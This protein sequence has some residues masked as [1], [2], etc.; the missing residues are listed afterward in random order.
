MAGSKA[1]KWGIVTLAAV[2][3]LVAGG[4]IG[5]RIVVGITKGKVVEALGPE[6]EIQDLKVGWF[7][8]EI[9]GLRIKG[10]QG[11]PA[12]D[13][14]RVERVVIAPSLRSLLS[15]TIRIS[16]ITVVRPYLSALRTCFEVIVDYKYV[17][18]SRKMA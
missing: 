11:W 10:R 1:M 17:N 4:I 9:K 12:A 16:S 14:L 18:L 5:L 8:V 6:S 2:L 7:T 3:V 15:D 13:T